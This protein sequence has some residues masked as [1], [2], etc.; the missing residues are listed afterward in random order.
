MVLQIT[1]QAKDRMIEML[2]YEEND[3]L[4]LRLGVN[5]EGC[6]GLSYSLRFDEEFD[7]RVDYL[8]DIN[9][10]PVTV[11]KV[12]IDIV[13]GTIIDFKQNMMGGGFTVDNPNTVNSCGCDSAAKA[14]DRESVPENC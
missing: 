7:Q 9:M 8:T 13:T 2:N 5:D 10:I 12:D 3:R 14:E 6:N 4:R 11:K 1:Q